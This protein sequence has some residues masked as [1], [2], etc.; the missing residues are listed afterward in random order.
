MPLPDCDEITESAELATALG[1]YIGPLATIVCTDPA[2]DHID[3]IY[4]A[5]EETLRVATLLCRNMR[6]DVACYP[7]SRSSVIFIEAPP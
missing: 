7:L 3:L 5:K 6:I 4:A 1:L 2:G